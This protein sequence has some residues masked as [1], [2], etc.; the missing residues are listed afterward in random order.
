MKFRF[1]NE[2]NLAFRQF[3]DEAVSEQWVFLVKRNRKLQPA[4]S[5]HNRAYLNIR[6]W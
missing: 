6:W 5:N 4:K 3:V 2:I 1:Q